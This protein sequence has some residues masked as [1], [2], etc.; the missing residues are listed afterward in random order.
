MENV[1]ENS[2]CLLPAGVHSN[3]DAADAGGR[4]VAVFTEGDLGGISKREGTVLAPMRVCDVWGSGVNELRVSL[5]NIS[6]HLEYVSGSSVA[7]GG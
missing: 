1:L 2:A 5:S 3:E 4:D 6:P 7:S